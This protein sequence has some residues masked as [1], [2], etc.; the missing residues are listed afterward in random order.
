[1]P[2][3]GR[4]RGWS[5]RSP[6]VGRG[7]DSPS[8]SLRD[9]PI[10]MAAPWAWEQATGARAPPIRQC[11]LPGQRRCLPE[12]IALRR[13][14]HLAVLPRPQDPLKP[15][16]TPTSLQPGSLTSGVKGAAPSHGHSEAGAAT[17]TWG[18]VCR[19]HRPSPCAPRVRTG[20]GWGAQ[21][22]RWALGPRTVSGG[23]DLLVPQTTWQTQ[24]SRGAAGSP[25]P[26]SL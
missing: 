4:A 26:C 1:M 11:G 19:Q 21:A 23:A 17:R 5:W 22:G 16:P 12:G 8:R 25:A 3:S 6:A 13:A 10:C 24:P 18:S 20:L 9:P 2:P 7:G 15:P 14:G